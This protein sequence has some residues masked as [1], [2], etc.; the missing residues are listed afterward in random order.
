MADRTGVPVTPGARIPHTEA[1]RAAI[2]A[3]ADHAGTRSA[4][5]CEVCITSMTGCEEGERLRRAIRDATR[6]RAGERRG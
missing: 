2:R 4:P 1:E 3:L 6:A 5:G